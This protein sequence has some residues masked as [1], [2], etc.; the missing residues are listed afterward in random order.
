[1][2]LV[3]AAAM[4]LLLVQA[5]EASAVPL[6]VPHVVSISPADGSTIPSGPFDLTVTFDRPMLAGSYS[7][8]RVSPATFPDCQPNARLSQDRTSYTMRCTAVAGR[9][10]EVWFN[11]PPYMN[12]KSAEGISAQPS[13]TRFRAR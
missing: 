6:A 1:M 13:R 12:F 4:G 7:F 9:V 8:V 10:Y 3:A 5:G 2:V 11:R